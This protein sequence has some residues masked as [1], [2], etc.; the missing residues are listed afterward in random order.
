MRL[1]QYIDE[2][3]E[4]LIKAGVDSPRLCAEVLAREAL[5][6]DPS[7]SA[8]LFCILEA[9]REVTGSEAKLL[10]ALTAQRATGRPLAQIIGRKEFYGRDFVVTRHTLVPRPETELIVDN[11]L[12]LLP[13][14]ALHF[15]DLG[16]GTGCIGITL[17]AERPRWS[18]ILL[19]ICPNAIAVA[20]QNAMRHGV[21]ERISPLCGDMRTPPLKPESLGLL[22]S[23]P[24]YIADAERGMVMDEVL[25]HE[26]HGALFS[27][28]NGLHHLKAAITAAAVALE[29]GGWVLLEHG[30]S[31]AQAVHDLLAAQGIF[32]K[33]ENKR[34]IA[35]L[36]RCTLAQKGL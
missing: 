7:G 2:T 31:Q 4:Q 35:Q 21:A 26:P 3:T 23:N 5:K 17:A 20:A 32:K 12:E 29:N 19:D 27:E 8:R 34:D 30:A 36:N 6:G 25:R 13:G 10:R 1:K 15:A 22:V 14:N 24:P 9:R 11:A 18:G 33:I 16:T 28:N